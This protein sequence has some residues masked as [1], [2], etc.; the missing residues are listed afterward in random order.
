MPDEVTDALA[1]RLEKEI[2]TVRDNAEAEMKSRLIEL[3]RE[4]TKDF[5]AKFLLLLTTVAALA[6]AGILSSVATAARKAN[7]AVITLQNDVISKQKEIISSENVVAT[8]RV[9]V[10]EAEGSLI[11]KKAELE[12]LATSYR[13]SQERLKTAQEAYEKARRDFEELALRLR[14]IAASVTQTNQPA[15]K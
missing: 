6:V 10:T 5:R 3:E 2:A 1:K 8:A 7:E 14:A 12:A 11:A 13:D 9:K 15:T 4:F